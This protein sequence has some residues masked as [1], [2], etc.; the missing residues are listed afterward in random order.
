MSTHTPAKLYRTTIVIWSDFDPRDLEISY[1]A[2]D[3][4]SGDSF[5][6]TLATVEV[7]DPTQF[8]ETEFFGD[9]TC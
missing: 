5:C 7:T 1:L 9:G 3:A 4:E 8:P 2:R 6:E